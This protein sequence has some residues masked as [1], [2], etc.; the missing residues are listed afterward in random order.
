MVAETMPATSDAV[1]LLGKQTQKKPVIIKE[2]AKKFK[3][4]IIIIKQI[5][6]IY[7]IF[8]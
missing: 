2:K 8:M 4:N 7:V 3:L 5:S 6:L 1:P